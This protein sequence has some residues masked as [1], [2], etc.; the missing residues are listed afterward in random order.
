MKD[1]IV[2]GTT[3]DLE[4]DET[5]N[6]E[7]SYLFSN[8]CELNAIVKILT[9]ESSSFNPQDIPSGQIN[10]DC[11]A[12]D[13]QGNVFKLGLYFLPQYLD[14]QQ[15]IVSEITKGKILVVRG[16]Y[17]VLPKRE[18]IITVNDPKYF[19]LPNEY[20]LEEVE[21]V[22][23]F[24]S[25][26]I[27][28]DIHKTV[29]QGDANAQLPTKYSLED[30]LR[31]N[32]ESLIMDIHKAAE[33]GDANSQCELGEMYQEGEGVKQS[34]AEAAKWYRKAAEQGHEN[35]QYN[36]GLMY[37][38]GGGVTRNDTEATK[39][40]LKA[41]EQGHENAQYNVGFMYITGKGVP[42]DDA[43]AARWFRMA[44]VQG[45][46]EAQRKM[47]LMY[48]QGIGVEQDDEEAEEWFRLSKYDERRD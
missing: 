9:V 23:R 30:V 36:L 25:A 27:T 43:E 41:A 19:Q 46:A 29:E 7:P 2:T 47:G 15:K 31:F 26:L 21:E 8:G 40:F 42:R 12:L 48:E 37:Q 33:Q 17:C 32:S 13:C 22:F 34:Y 44:A 28:M 18:S 6:I 14:D 3:M 4:T 39:W 11:L 5:T 16:R 10:I 45:N 24:N 1:K 20:S 38:E 35:A